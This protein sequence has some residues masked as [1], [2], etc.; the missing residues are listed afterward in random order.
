MMHFNTDT[1]INADKKQWFIADG[2]R[3]FDYEP[4]ATIIPG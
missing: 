4:I 1:V 3:K 2:A